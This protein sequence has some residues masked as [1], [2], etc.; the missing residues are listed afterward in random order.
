METP[1]SLPSTVSKSRQMSASASTNLTLN[2]SSATSTEQVNDEHSP[3]NSSATTSAL[4]RESIENASNEKISIAV[5]HTQHSH[6]KRQIS[7]AQQDRFECVGQR[8]KAHACCAFGVTTHIHLFF[9]QYVF[10]LFR[11]I[12]SKYYIC[13]YLRSTCN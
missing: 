4:E 5:P 7:F 9:Q 13:I 3:S 1:A 6:S 12:I 8:R 2:A 11:K 10:F